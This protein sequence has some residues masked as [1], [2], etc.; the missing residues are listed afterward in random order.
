MSVANREVNGGWRWPR[1]IPL[2]SSNPLPS[3]VIIAPVMLLA[4]LALFTPVAADTYYIHANV[5]TVDSRNRHVGC[6]GVKG[7]KIV[8]VENEPPKSRGGARIVDLKGA[9]VFP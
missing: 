1:R 7:D 2:Q 4:C 8:Y 3:R 9:T 5:Y 6:I